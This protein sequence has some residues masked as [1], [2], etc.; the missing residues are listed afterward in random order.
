MALNFK[1]M[2]WSVVS[3]VFKDCSFMCNVIFMKNT[4]YRISNHIRAKKIQ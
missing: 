3:N 4:E 1:L 2:N